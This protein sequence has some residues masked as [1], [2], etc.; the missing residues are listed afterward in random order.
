MPEKPPDPKLKNLEFRAKLPQIMRM[1]AIGGIAVT[2]IAVGIGFYLNFGKEDFRMK[3]LKELQLSKD[4][5]AEFDRYERRENDGENL[6][7]LI[8]ADKVRTFSD[9]HQ[10]LENIFLQVFDKNSETFDQI[11]AEQAIYV[12][13]KD[14]SK[15]FTAFFAGDVKIVSRDGLNVKTDQLTYKKATEIAEAEEYIEFS[16]ENVKGSAIGAIVKTRE[17]ELE[18]LRD[19]DITAFGSDDGELKSIEVANI[20]SGKA[21]FDQQGQRISFTEQVHIDVV[22]KPGSGENLQPTS[23][24]AQKAEAI[25]VDKELD[26]ID[27]S[28]NV[29]V[30]QKPQESGGKWS[31]TR[32]NRAIA[33]IEKE[34]KRLELFENVEIETSTGSDQPTRVKTGYALYQKDADRFELKNGVEIVT[35]KGG[36]PTTIRSQNAIFEQS[37]G[38]IVLNGN[39]EIVQASEYVSGDH[40]TAYLVKN[41]QLKSAN[42][43]GNA[44][45]KQSTPERATEVSAAELNAIFGE[46]QKLLSANT[47]GKSTATMIPARS[48]EYTRVS[49]SVPQAIRLNFIAGSLDKMETQGRTTI[50]LESPVSG[51]D[52]SNKKL[53]ADTVRTF[54][55]DGGTDLT[56]AEAVGTAELEIIPHKNTV[57]SYK[58]NVYAPRFDCEFF[59]GNNAKLCSA[60]GS[61]KAVRK[62]TAARTDRGTQTLTSDKMDAFFSEQTKDLDR[63]EAVGNA[64]FNELDRNGIADR[65]AFTTGDSTVRLRGGEPTLWDSQARIKSGEIDWN[66]NAERS[67]FRD[68][69]ST[70]YYSQKKTGGATPFRDLNSP[71]FLTANAAEIDHKTEV[72]V[73]TGNAR[74]W[75]DNNYVRAD[76]LTIS[77]KEGRL[78]GEG[79]VQS[80]LYDAKR[81]ENGREISVPVYASS[82]RLIYIKDKNFIQYAGN[83]DIRQQ[84]DRITAGVA[85]IYLNDKN[86]VTL[87]VAEQNVLITQ[88]G[89]K[90]SGSY[91]KY[92]AVD[93]SVILRGDPARIE[94]KENG[95]S[96]AAQ[97]TVF[98]RENRVIAEGKTPDSNSQ[99]I[100]SVYK[101]KND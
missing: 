24:D 76:R 51:E 85:N 5:I 83:A 26:R 48:A 9:N 44:F 64:K 75:Q 16:R 31:K 23:I 12:P 13:D 82:D 89:R 1:F 20:T 28:G 60:T 4:V 59:S 10:E 54:W 97:M 91:A 11:T 39:A 78:N 72:A 90:A 14:N 8:K 35:A 62:P 71:V 38:R 81:K 86:E 18:L 70:T 87:T 84:P 27:L 46:D 77:Q 101:V 42:V 94:D 40:I 98:M 49:M 99:R 69:V 88:P 30:H 63:F 45:L 33:E 57:A 2:L 53:I 96:Q 93:E 36:E 68:K 7:Y 25:F 58:T 73:Y 19:V 92:D 61:A 100:R 37:N 79:S 66:T 50:S 95:T 29:F 65:I 6:N 15:S 17:K 47:L 67:F 32:A 80:L 34:V 41:N 43:K 22:P 3:G 56:R 21:F 55:N 52:S 74:A